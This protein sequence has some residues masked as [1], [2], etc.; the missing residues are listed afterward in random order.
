MKRGRTETDTFG[1]IEVDNRF[2]SVPW[3]ANVRPPT[4]PHSWMRSVLWGAQTQRSLQNFP[5]GG[6]GLSP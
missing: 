6:V 1:P 3:H 5:I 4:V 2:L